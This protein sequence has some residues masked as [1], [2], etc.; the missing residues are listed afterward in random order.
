M[1]D[2]WDRLRESD[3]TVAK[4]LRVGKRT[5]ECASCGEYFTSPS[6]FDMHRID[7]GSANTRCATVAQMSQMG[8]KQNTNGVWYSDG[9]RKERLVE[10]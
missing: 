3:K 10:D 1:S 9:A 4:E 2:Q 5:C 6:G 7:Y 8:M